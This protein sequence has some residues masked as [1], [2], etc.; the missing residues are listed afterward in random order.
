MLLRSLCARRVDLT[1]VETFALLGVAQQV[2]GTC[3]LLELLFG[4][5]VGCNFFASLRYAF[6]ISAE[7]AVGATPRTSYGF[8]TTYS[9]RILVR[10]MRA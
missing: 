9:A 10:I 1:V 6:W 3:G 7:E 8:L 2:V 5:L 4:R